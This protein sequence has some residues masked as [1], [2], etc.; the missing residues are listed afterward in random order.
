MAPKKPTKFRH[1]ARPYGQENER[2]PETFKVLKAAEREAEEAWH[3]VPYQDRS[4]LLDQRPILWT[5]PGQRPALP[6]VKISARAAE[7]KTPS[8]QSRWRLT[9]RGS[10]RP[11]SESMTPSTPCA[12]PMLPNFSSLASVPAAMR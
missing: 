1:G 7:K 10:R 11:S 2:D 12:R 8:G 3:R 4:Q 5:E 9:S 6:P